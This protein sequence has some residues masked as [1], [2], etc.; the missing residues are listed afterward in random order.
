MTHEP[1]DITTGYLSVLSAASRLLQEELP[2]VQRIH[3]LFGLLR[4]AIRYRDAR[5]TCWLQS[6]R[7][8]A[9]R[10][11]IFSPGRGLIRGTIP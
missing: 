1:E 6:A 2:L 7:P 10:Q 5:L 8:G 11:Q 3:R 9:H 4:L